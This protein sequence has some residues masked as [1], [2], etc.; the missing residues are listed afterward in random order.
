MMIVYNDTIVTTL[1]ECVHR[2][3]LEDRDGDQLPSLVVKAYTIR[4]FIWDICPE[5]RGVSLNWDYEGEIWVAGIT[6]GLL[7]EYS[8][9][10]QA[11]ARLKTAIRDE[12][13]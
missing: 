11:I 12:L 3:A 1:L 2:I 5:L 6:E 7:R 9:P 13:M 8:T 4:N 10:A